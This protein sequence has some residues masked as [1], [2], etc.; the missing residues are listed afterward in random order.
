MADS[1][2]LEALKER[3]VELDEGVVGSIK[4][5]N[6]FLLLREEV[7]DEHYKYKLVRFL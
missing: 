1:V 2:R 5:S 3:F 4:I 6:N 7:K